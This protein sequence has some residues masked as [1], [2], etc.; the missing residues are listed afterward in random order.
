MTVLSFNFA[1]RQVTQTSRR[2]KKVRCGVKGKADYWIILGADSASGIR[3]ENET[4]VREENQN[5]LQNIP[6]FFVKASDK[7]FEQTIA[8][9]QSFSPCFTTISTSPVVDP[10]FQKDKAGNTVQNLRPHN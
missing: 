2:K 4:E 9:P 6:R 7:W 1:A 8:L 10:T 5:I 3:T